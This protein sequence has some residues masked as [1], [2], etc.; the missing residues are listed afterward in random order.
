MGLELFCQEADIT[1]RLGLTCES[2]AAQFRGHRAQDIWQIL[3]RPV[4]RVPHADDHG[5]ADRTA[6]DQ[7]LQMSVHIP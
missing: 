5:W 2:T 3:I 6:I 7:G 4:I 1:I